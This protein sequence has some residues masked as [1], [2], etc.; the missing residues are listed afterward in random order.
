M[1]GQMAGLVPAPAS[2]DPEPAPAP[3]PLGKMS[4]GRRAGGLAH[5]LG[6]GVVKGGLRTDASLVPGLADRASDDTQARHTA[7]IS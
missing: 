4:V 2:A 6:A 3:Q 1:A 5:R 7:L